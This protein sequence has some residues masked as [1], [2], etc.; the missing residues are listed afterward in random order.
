MKLSIS[1]VLFATLLSSS[2][3]AAS[4]QEKYLRASPKKK[5]PVQDIVSKWPFQ[6]ALKN[7]SD[8]KSVDLLKHR[9]TEEKANYSVAGLV[10]STG[11]REHQRV[12]KKKKEAQKEKKAKAKALRSTDNEAGAYELKPKHGNEKVDGAIPTH[13]QIET[14]IVGGDQSGVGEF[15]Y[16]GALRKIEISSRVRVYT[17]LLS[18]CFWS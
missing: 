10:G 13:N 17:T 6:K 7:A 11:R 1:A 16:Y 18:R 5:Q 9:A 4:K 2:D 15:P 8:V 12:N 14:H 3:A